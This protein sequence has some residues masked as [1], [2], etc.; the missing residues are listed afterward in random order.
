MRVVGYDIHW[1]DEF[2]QQNAI[3]RLSLPNL[4]AQSDVVSLH[5]PSTPETRELIGTEELAMMKPGARLINTARGDIV[6]Q[7][8]LYGALTSGHLAGAALDV[9]SVEPPEG[10]PL[11]RLENVI[12][13]VHLGGE[14]LEAQLR[15]S[16]MATDGVLSVVKGERP[17]YLVNPDVYDHLCGEASA[18]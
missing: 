3:E 9:W 17:Q 12:A 16:Q 6:D 13:T 14:S 18:G 5:I 15:M 10:N 1:D 11:V 8:A 7:G 2:A 4:L